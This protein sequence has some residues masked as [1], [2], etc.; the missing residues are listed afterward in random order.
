MPGLLDIQVAAVR[1]NGLWASTPFAHAAVEVR[2]GVIDRVRVP[3]PRRSFPSRE[4]T[5][6]YMRT[7]ALEWL[8]A[9]YHRSVA[10]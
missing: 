6:S 5:E 4:E 10:G 2:A 1:A 8:A 7:F 3:I 9:H